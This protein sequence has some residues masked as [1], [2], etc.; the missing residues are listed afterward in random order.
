MEL[1][2]KK[3]VVTG[4]AQGIGGAVVRAYAG[5]GATIASMD[6]KEDLGRTVAAEA[7]RAGPG[8]ARFY[9]LDVTKRDDVE[10]KFKQAADDMGGL[11]VLV[12]VAG[13]QNFVT[14]EDVTP[15]AYERLFGVNVLGTMYTNGVAYHLM[16]PK[17]AGNIIN[18]GSESGLTGE[19]NNAVYGASKGAVHT[20]TRTVARQWGPDGIRVNA[21]L[22]YVVTPMYAE[23][24][25]N[26]S[27]EDLR[28][29][30]SARQPDCTN[31]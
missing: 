1:Q 17:K 7:S 23:F 22:P 16:K 3:I 19:L 6:L 2:G 9:S 13:V 4:G 14:P 10:A 30:A 18:F 11:D 12:N 25:K 20:W 15:E 21:V 29:H 8:K 31:P 5:V 28:A 26:L 27:P 24:R